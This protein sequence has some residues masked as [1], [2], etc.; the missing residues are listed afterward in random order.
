VIADSIPGNPGGDVAC[1]VLSEERISF[2]WAFPNAKQ[3][4]IAG[5]FNDWKAS[6]TP[7]KDC[8]DGSWLLDL[9]LKPG[10]YEYRFVVDGKWTDD[11]L[12]PGCAPN[13]FGG[14]NSVLV[15]NVQNGKN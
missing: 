6:S 10:R 7:L 9:A 5:S 3:V 2:K 12:S 4:F 14:H 13:P 1:R 15:V 11:P 8:G